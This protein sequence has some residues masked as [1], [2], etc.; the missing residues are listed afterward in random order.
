MQPAT[1]PLDRFLR[2]FTDVRDGEGFTALLLALNV[3]LILMAYYVLKPVR[4]ALI[5]GE[6]TAELKTYLSAIE[7]IL[8]AFIVPVYGRLVKR[9]D[10]RRLINTVTGFFVVCLV[11]FYV[12]GHAGVPLGIPFFL[13]ISIFNMMI[14]A[15]FWSF[16]ND[17]Y[18][19]DEGERL[20]PVVGFGASLGAVV[21]AGFAGGFIQRIGVFELLL[22]GAVLLVV[23]VMITNFID[24]RSHAHATLKAVTTSSPTPTRSAPPAS[25]TG[26]FG[27][28]FKTR[29]LLMIALML[30]LHNGVKTTGEYLLGNA[31]R[32]SAIAELGPN[33]TAGI[34][35]TV[36]SFYSS[37][38][39][40]VN[41]V[42]L[43]LQLF[44]VSRI[45]RYFGVPIAVLIL[46]LTALAAYGVIAFLPL[47]RAIFWAKVSEN[48]TDYSLNNT[49]RNMLFL[50]CTTEQKYS[51]KQAI[52]SFFVRLGDVMAAVVV[53]VG[54][55]WLALQPRGF[56]LVN[57]V[58][59][60]LWL[61]LAWRIGRQYQQLSV[62][63]SH[64]A[65]AA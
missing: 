25:K 33:D 26:A 62:T 55:S 51:A 42:G 39:T 49:V 1:R 20:F 29:Y 47:L 24:A 5:L 23:E 19:K 35:R 13:W 2:L 56:A 36:G 63:K 18:S 8:L 21:G 58:M 10:R 34:Q 32:Q 9:M 30:M 6:G 4:E 46:P 17:L 65:T 40:Y 60:A 15:Q 41:I 52:D 7:V 61:V 12:L 16:A 27:M 50:P 64:P 43:L 11:V 38:Y 53:F 31:V 44:V 28:V 57:A 54:T 37:F 14:V 22:V 48:A 3:F 45:V 59:V